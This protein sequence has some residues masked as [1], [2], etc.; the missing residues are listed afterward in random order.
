MAVE[1]FAELFPNAF[2]LSNAEPTFVYHD[3]VYLL[4]SVQ[5]TAGSE[6]VECRAVLD[7]RDRYWGVFD[8]EAQAP[9][10][11]VTERPIRTS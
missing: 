9:L 1:K 5:I 8:R 4:R 10:P 11:A 3:Q 7:Q 2:S 6:V